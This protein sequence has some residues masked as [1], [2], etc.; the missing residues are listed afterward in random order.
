VP[1]GNLHAA[2]RRRL[3]L[4][5]L[6]AL[7]A[8]RLA[9][10]DRTTAGAPEGALRG[11]T[12]RATAAAATGTP[13]EAAPGGTAT[14]TTTE[15][16]ATAAASAATARTATRGGTLTGTADGGAAG[17]H[18]RVGT[19]TAGARSGTRPARTGTARTLAGRRRGTLGALGTLAG[20]GHALARRERVVAR[21]RGAGTRAALP[22]HALAR[23]ERVVARPRRAGTRTRATGTGRGRVRAATRL[24]GRGGL[25]LPRRR[26]GTLRGGGLR[27]RGLRGR[28]GRGRGL[29]LRGTRGGGS[30]SRRRGRGGLGLG[31]G[32][33]GRLRRGRTGG[34]GCRRGLA[35]A[36]APGGEGVAQLADH[37]WL[38]GRG[39]RADELTELRQLGHDG[40]AFHPELLRELV[41]ADLCHNSPVSARPGQG[42]PSLVLGAHR[43]VLIGCPSASNP[44]PCRRVVQCGPAGRDRDAWLSRAPPPAPRSRC[45]PRRGRGAP[46]RA[47]PAGRPAGVPPPR[48][49]GSTRG[50]THR[51]P[52][53]TARRPPRAAARRCSRRTG[54]GPDGEELTAGRA[55]GI[56]RTCG[57]D[58]GPSGR[59]GSWCP[60]AWSRCG[61]AARSMTV[62]R[63]DPSSVTV[64]RPATTGRQCEDLR[65]RPRPTPR[66]ACR[67]RRSGCRCAS[68]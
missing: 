50:A 67:R 33:R 38:D 68:P 49:T 25:L 27:C 18:A 2:E 39:C 3:H 43:W 45:G 11:T 51:D 30:G 62:Y 14:G 61:R 1:A 57:Q 21:A 55:P 44:L 12:T 5:E 22:G 59:G 60:G 7:R 56:R 48:G 47:G 36:A 54:R 15:A 24:R 42:G 28:G 29:R 32:L 53:A 17:H 26:R 19:R 64:P 10:A 31:R 41:D 23:G 16:A 20:P 63:A 66:P 46:R 65:E 4:L 9:P 6:L 13:R 52:A 58:P 40:L 35:R 8:L 37:R 34:G